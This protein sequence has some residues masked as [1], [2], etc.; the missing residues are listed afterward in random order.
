MAV[1]SYGDVVNHP[2]SPSVSQVINSI[3]AKPWKANIEAV[4]ID[5]ITGT[6]ARSSASCVREHPG[7][8]G[9]NLADPILTSLGG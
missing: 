6:I 1:S 3:H 8:Q 7:L 9:V 5:K 2:A 4:V